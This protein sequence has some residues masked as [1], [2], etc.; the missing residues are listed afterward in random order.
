MFLP[1]SVAIAIDAPNECPANH[2][3]PDPAVVTVLET[4]SKCISDLVRDPVIVARKA[5]TN[6]GGCWLE[7]LDFTES[8]IGPTMVKRE[9]CVHA[10]CFH[11]M[12]VCKE[13]EKEKLLHKIK[14]PR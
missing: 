1:A 6:L 5:I 4:T 7:E 10:Q 3:F 13:D 12:V 8:E 11:T 14:R 2:T 9:S